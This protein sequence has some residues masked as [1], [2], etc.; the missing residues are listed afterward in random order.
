MGG[1]RRRNRLATGKPRAFMCPIRRDPDGHRL[2]VARCKTRLDRSRKRDILLNLKNADILCSQKSEDDALDLNQDEANV[3][4]VLKNVSFLQPDESQIQ[5]IDETK[6][7]KT[8][9]E[10]EDEDGVVFLKKEKS[11]NLMVYKKRKTKLAEALRSPYRQRIIQIGRKRELIEELVADWIFSAN[12]G[13]WD[14]LFENAYVDKAPRICMESFYPNEYLHIGVLSCWATIINNEEQYRSNM[15]PTRLFCPCNMMGENNF[16][17]WMKNTE[18]LQHFE[19]NVNVALLGSQF[20][21]INQINLLIIRVLQTNHFY[22]VCFNLKNPAIEIVDNI[23]G[24]LHA[25][26]AA[27]VRKVQKIVAL[28]LEKES[29]ALHKKIVNLKPK[30]L[31]MPWQTENNFFDCGIFAMRHMETY[32]AKE[33]KEWKEDCGILEESSGKQHDQ[34]LDLRLKYLSKILSSDINILHDEVTKEV[35]NFEE[36]YEEVKKKMRRTAHKRIQ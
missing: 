5:P 1:D 21:S 24:R 10:N 33:M 13:I 7:E 32:K 35:K 12:G 4:D 3:E 23:R 27:N 22:L 28:Y 17:R 19:T 11:K 9:Q 25:R 6:G 29:P 16:K 36:L 15:S 34:L 14:I 20:N 8:E 30:K 31:E 18:M 26:C 2:R